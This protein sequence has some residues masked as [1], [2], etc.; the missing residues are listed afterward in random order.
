MTQRPQLPDAR[1]VLSATRSPL[2]PHRWLLELDCG[3]EVWVT[4]G[5]AGKSFRRKKFPCR[6]CID[7]AYAAAEVTDP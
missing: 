3:H 4:A 2:N 7:A 5:N 6:T 1:K